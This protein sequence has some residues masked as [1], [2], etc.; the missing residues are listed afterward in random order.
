MPCVLKAPDFCALFWLQPASLTPP[1][2]WEWVSQVEAWP[3]IESVSVWKLDRRWD[4][5]MTTLQW[6]IYTCHQCYVCSKQL[7]IGLAFGSSQIFGPLL[8]DGKMF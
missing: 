2:G 1:S 8:Q 4:Q 5:G 6:Y 7:A 3:S